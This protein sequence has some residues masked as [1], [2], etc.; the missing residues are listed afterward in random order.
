MISSGTDIGTFFYKPGS[1]SAE[2]DIFKITVHGKQSHGAAPW[3]G[4]DPI[5][6]ASQI[7]LGLQTIISRN[8]HLTDDAAVITVGTFN[9][10]NR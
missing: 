8:V 5:V 3:A 4:V 7:V 2:N 9:A 1:V 6:T 10:G